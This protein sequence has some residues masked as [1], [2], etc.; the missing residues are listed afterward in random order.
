MTVLTGQP[1]PGSGHGR[2]QLRQAP[3]V[4]GEQAGMTP[5]VTGGGAQPEEVPARSPEGPE[6][7]DRSVAALPVSRRC[8]RET[9]RAPGEP[10]PGVRAGR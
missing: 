4:S 7:G 1:A 10:G 8:G 3:P 6:P 2:D 5:V 9:V